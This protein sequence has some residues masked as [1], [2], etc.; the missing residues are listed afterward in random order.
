MAKRIVG[1]DV[2]F[3]SLRAAQVN[4][5]YKGV[6]LIEK[7][8]ELKYP[9]GLVEFGEIRDRSAFTKFLKEFWDQQKF[10]TRHVALAA[11]SLHVFARELSV[12]VMS[13][14]RIKESL[15][16]M[17]EGILPVPAEQLYI[18]FYP[19]EMRSDAS[20]QTV[21]GLAV[22]A[23]KVAVDAL[24]NCVVDAR[25][26]PMAVDFIPFALA[27]VHLGPETPNQ[28]NVL[29]DIGAGA[30][31]VVIAVGTVPQF[32]RVI[33]NGGQDVDR[34]LM[35]GLNI[36]EEDAAAVKVRLTKAPRAKGDLAAWNIMQDSIKEF[37][38]TVKNTFDYY[39]QSHTNDA[40]PIAGIMLSGGGSHLG[41]L[42]E[43]FEK[44]FAVPVVLNDAAS[45]IQKAAN[46]KVNDET[47][48]RMAIAVGLA[49][50]GANE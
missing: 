32:V 22:A 25:L 40:K 44:E 15:P 19:A 41:G 3:T 23:E 33:P 4:F 11:G 17:M 43:T 13:V 5:T 2:G 35:V 18:D 7:V 10:A 49:L 47:L 27:R 46:L 30:T 1:L 16:F 26:R 45:H 36:P 38:T 42:I 39:Q 37:V 12:P 24:V 20:G 28:L 8:A 50:G 48:E 6:P 31:N 21:H 34:D 14:Q 29:I 9:K